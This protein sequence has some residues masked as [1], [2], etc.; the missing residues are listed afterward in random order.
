MRKALATVAVLQAGLAAAPAQEW[1]ADAV[2]TNVTFTVTHM[3]VAE[4]SGRFKEFTIALKQGKEDFSGS[5]VEATVK[6]AS[7]STDNETRDN[8]LRSDD[9]F[10]VE[11]YPAMTFTSTSFE[12]TGDDTYKITGDLTIRDVT[13]PVTFDAKL[14]GTVTDAR[15]T[16]VGFR[17]TTEINRFDYGVKWDRT[18]DTGGF[19]VSKNVEI[20]ITAE[21]VKQK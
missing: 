20:K 18:L 15:G 14:L 5:T 19:I 12:K 4:V 21:M 13:K 1:K 3:L 11:K 7:L 9:F 17:A 6:T 8:H 16:R 10:N 2:H